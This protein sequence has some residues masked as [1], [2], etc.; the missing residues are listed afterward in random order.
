MCFLNLQIGGGGVSIYYSHPMQMLFFSYANGK[1]FMAPMKS[2]AEEIETLFHINVNKTG[3][4]T[5]SASR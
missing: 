2:V 3:T 5:T 1:S 4:S